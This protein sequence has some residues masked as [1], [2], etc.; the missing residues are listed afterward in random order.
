MHVFE[1]GE[2]PWRTT[3]VPDLSYQWVWVCK[4][5]LFRI[6]DMLFEGGMEDLEG[7][8]DNTWIEKAKLI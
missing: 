6:F 7:W 3:A 5:R 8:V 1:D 4:S 2:E